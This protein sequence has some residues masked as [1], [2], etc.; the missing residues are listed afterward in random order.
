MSADADELL[1]AGLTPAQWPKR[2]MTIGPPLGPPAISAEQAEEMARKRF[3]GCTDPVATLVEMEVPTSQ[4]VQSTTCWAI[5]MTPGPSISFLGGPAG[6]PTPRP[7]P[8]HMMVFLDA[9]SGRMVIAKI[10]S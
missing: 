1:V 6:R 7:P 8:A 2:G 4:V 9:Q 3:T 10:W 5:S